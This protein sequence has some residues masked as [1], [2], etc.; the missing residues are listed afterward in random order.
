MTPHPITISSM[1]HAIGFHRV[2]RGYDGLRWKFRRRDPL[3]G[4]YVGRVFYRKLDK[5][6]QQ[7]PLT[8]ANVVLMLMDLDYLAHAND[9]F[10]HAAVDEILRDAGRLIRRY[11]DRNGIAA[12]LGGDEFGILLSNTSVDAAV[13]FAD[14]LRIEMGR[15][16]A[17]RAEEIRDGAQAAGVTHP[18]PNVLT[19]SIGVVESSEASPRSADGLLAIAESRMWAAKA[20]G[21]NCICS[22]KSGNYGDGHGRLFARS[23]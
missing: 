6:V 1:L 7:V 15:A 23:I 17:I 12:R 14:G 2:A 4:L 21:R 22:T 3:T 11:T 8:N 10:G 16:T 19:L 20:A 9:V 5:L 18:G 13:K